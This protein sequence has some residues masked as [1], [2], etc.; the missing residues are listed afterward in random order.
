MGKLVD[1]V[2]VPNPE[3]ATNK[4][5]RF[6]R[7]D[8]S[9]RDWVS[10][11][12]STAFPAESGRYHLYVSY[13]CPWAH[14]TLI[15]RALKCLEDHISVTVVDAHLG[16][17]GWSFGVSGDETVDTLNQKQF[18]YEIYQMAKPNYTGKVTVP[19][20]WDKKSKTIVSNESAEIIR[21]LNRAFH[22]LCER[23]VDYCPDDLLAEIDEVN[24]FVYSN[25][26]NG[27]YKCG[28]AKS[29]KAYEHAFDALFN[30]LD[31]IEAR[32]DKSRYL[33]GNE[34]TEA[35]I[36]LFTTLVR[37]D[38]VYVGHFK[39]NLRRI[40]DYPNLSNYL[41]DLY[42]YRGI[43]KTVHF[44]HIKQHYYL[45]HTTI[46]PTQVIPKGPALD[47]DAPHDRAARFS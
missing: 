27:V 1:G 10:H 36:R 6:V 35:D 15:M 11:D 30:A 42:Q 3:L 7:E 29:Q 14:R 24:A 33:L 34:I 44:D 17:S 28:F 39:T 38:A 9:F 23:Q 2:W 25:I 32:L 43:A 47:F 26:N 21:M 46:N 5:G 22:H 20:L 18:L 13:A 37:F 12:G 19:V 8:S 4:D 45:S 40:A 41:R 31:E 16:E